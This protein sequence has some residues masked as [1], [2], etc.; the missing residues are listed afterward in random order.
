MITPRTCIDATDIRVTIRTHQAELTSEMQEVH[1]TTIH[2][3]HPLRGVLQSYQQA[4]EG[5]TSDS[6][7]LAIPDGEMRV[8]IELCDI[9]RFEVLST[10]LMTPAHAYSQ[11][12]QMERIVGLE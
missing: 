12:K 11:M 8:T 10:R 3:Q 6:L 5:T 7:T 2:L 1:I 9:S 4:P